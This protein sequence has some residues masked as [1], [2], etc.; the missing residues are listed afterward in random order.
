LPYGIPDGQETY[1]EDSNENQN[2]IPRMYA[3]RIGIDD[4]R[5]FRIPKSYDTILLLYP[6]KKQSDN[7]ADNSTKG[8]DNTSLKEEYTAYLTI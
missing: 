4:K 3:D 6:T 8:R 2:D 1:D 5:T 7:D